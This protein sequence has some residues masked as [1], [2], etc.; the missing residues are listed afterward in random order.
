MRNKYGIAQGAGAY[1]NT[2]IYSNSNKFFNR[3]DWIISNKHR[4]SIR[5]NTITSQATNLERDQ[6]NFRF[7]DIDFKQVNNQS[8]TVAELKSNFTSNLSNS[9]VLG[10][11]TIHD[12]REPS[13]NPSLPQIEIASNGGTIFLGTDR[14]ASIFNMKQKTYEFTDNFTWVKGNN[15]FTVGTHNELYDITYGFVNSWNGRVAYSSVNDF[16][17]NNP[18]RVRTNFNYTDNTRDYIMN[19]PPAAFKINLYS[20]YVQDEIRWGRLKLTPG[21][22]IDKADMPNKQPLSTKTTE[23]PVDV[24]Y[25]TTYT[26]THPKDIKKRFSWAGTGIAA[27]RIQL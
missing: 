24:N 2:S 6:Q 14:E 26:Y 16:L 4:L 3:L 12:Y 7:G 20:L 22:R 10:F 19:N 21:I 11:S 23:A 1:G 8:S 17:N 18:N 13:S 15:T 5:N 27:P 9:L 25:G